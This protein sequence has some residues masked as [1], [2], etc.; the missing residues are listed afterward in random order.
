MSTLVELERAEAENRF[1]AYL[2]SPDWDELWDNYASALGEKRPMM[3]YI[4]D[5]DTQRISPICKNLAE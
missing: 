4:R 1:P 3:A 2:R 5:R